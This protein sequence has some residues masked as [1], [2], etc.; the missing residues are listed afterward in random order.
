MYFVVV[1]NKGPC[2]IRY[3]FLFLGPPNKN[4]SNCEMNC[5]GTR[6]RGKKKK[7]LHAVILL[8]VWSNVT[9]E[10]MR[11]IPAELKSQ[12][13]SMLMKSLAWIL[14]LRCWRTNGAH[15]LQ[16]FRPLNLRPNPPHMLFI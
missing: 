11:L 16:L 13:H 10:V 2:F 9:V 8:K 1:L 3:F 4:S 14:C 6:K 7:L 5:M 12:G 15:F